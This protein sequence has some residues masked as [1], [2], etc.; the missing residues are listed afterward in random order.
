MKGQ[1]AV[2][3]L[4]GG[5]DSSTLLHQLLFEEFSVTGLTIDY[6]QRHRRELLAA[7]QIAEKAG[8][9]HKLIHMDSAL[10]PIFA[11]ARSSQVGSFVPVPEGHYADETMKATIVPNRN[12]LLLAVAGALAESIG[13]GFVAYAAH[14][15]DHPIYPDCRP[16]FYESC[17]LTLVYATDGRVRLYAPFGKIT[18]TDIVKRGSHYK[19]PFHLTYSCYAGRPEHCGKCGTCVERREAFRD[20]GVLDPTLYETEITGTPA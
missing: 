20:S 17:E 3:L 7:I 6:G 14:A 11:E 13:A 15:G 12:M 18:K 9:D 10:R 1:K 19:V 4:S 2:V 5:L 8:V 16:E